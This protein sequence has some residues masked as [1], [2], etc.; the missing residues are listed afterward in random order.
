MVKAT[1]FGLVLGLTVAAATLRAGTDDYRFTTIADSADGYDPFEFGC[2]AI[3][4]LGAV[5]FRAARV[6]GTTGIFRGRGGALVTIADQARDGLDFVGRNPSVNAAGV[7]SFAAN[8]EDGGSAILRGWG[9]GLTTIARA[10][11]GPFNF[12][13]FDTSLGLTGAVAFKGRADG[14]RRRPLRRP[15]RTAADRLPRVH[16]PVRGRRLR[17]LPER[18]GAGRVLRAPGRRRVRSLPVE[19]L[20]VHHDRPRQRAR[21]PHRPSVAEQRGASSRSRRSARTARAA[22]SPA[23]AAR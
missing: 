12:F 13:G 10:E 4:D 22:S 14:L 20:R 8:L 6:D 15:R 7:V 1:T 3:S 21:R 2:P 5:A 19:R 9:A 18:P 16:Q 17:A 11:P 23:A